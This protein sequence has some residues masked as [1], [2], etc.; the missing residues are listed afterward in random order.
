MHIDRD[1]AKNILYEGELD[2]DS[3]VPVAASLSNVEILFEC[4]RVGFPMHSFSIRRN[5]SGGLPNTNG[6]QVSNS[7]TDFGRAL[8]SAGPVAKI[9]E[10]AMASQAE[11]LDWQP[12]GRGSGYVFK[13]GQQFRFQRDGFR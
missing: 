13:R 8:S 11:L 1:K 3:L 10:I 7:L 9:D 5:I 4:N 6:N 2:R 12:A